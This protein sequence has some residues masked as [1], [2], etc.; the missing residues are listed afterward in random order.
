M[1][2][3]TDNSCK[4]SIVVP[5]YRSAP[6]LPQPVVLDAGPVERFGCSAGKFLGEY[7]A[8]ATCSSGMFPPFWRGLLPP[9]GTIVLPDGELQ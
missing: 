5:V 6:I 1:E 3:H 7:H 8:V 2:N 9:D 4:L